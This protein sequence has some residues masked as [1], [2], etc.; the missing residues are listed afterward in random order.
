MKNKKK[1]GN[2]DITLFLFII[3]AVVLYL[4]FFIYPILNGLY[5][6]MTDWDGITRQFNFTG[7]TNYINVMKDAR[8]RGAL[9]FTVTYALKLLVMVVLI[10]LVLAL[11]LNSKIKCKSAFRAVFFFPAVISMLTA[12]LIFN[13][14][15]YRVLPN[16]GELLN[17]EV[18]KSSI[19][20]NTTLAQYGI[21]FVHI[22]QSVAIPTVLIMAGLQSIPTE[23]LESA[24][25]DGA[26]KWQQFKHISVPFILPIVTVVVVLT[27]KD[28]LML[29]DYVV[30]LTQGGP[31]GATESVALLIYNHGFKEMKFSYG[32]A[33]SIILCIIVC[34]VSFIQI[35]INNKKKVY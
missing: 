31:A 32:I 1:I 3:P 23:L 11:L 33:E 15:F 20:S 2:R 35:A 18:L 25:L 6:S 30:G 8:F 16:I 17:I 7:L 22:W 26:T 5:Y 10:S 12:G 9:F 29:F 27:F 4:V 14:F 21:L 28:G 34:T 24:S 19:L 13:E